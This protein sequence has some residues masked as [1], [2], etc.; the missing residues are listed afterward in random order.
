MFITVNKIKYD[1]SDRA[2]LSG[3][4]GYSDS[5]TAERRAG[6]ESGTAT[7]LRPYIADGDFPGRSVLLI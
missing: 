5:T 6:F 1:G 4:A 7:F 2:D 3:F